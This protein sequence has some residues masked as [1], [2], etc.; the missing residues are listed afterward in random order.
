MSTL[1]MIYF[2]YFHATM[3]YGIIFW[4]NPTNNKKVFLQQKRIVRIMIGLTSGTSC[5][6]LFQRLELLTFSI[7]TVADEVLVT[8]FGNLYI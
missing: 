2:A 6:P 4:G 3:E 5:K 1:K 8:E 7:H